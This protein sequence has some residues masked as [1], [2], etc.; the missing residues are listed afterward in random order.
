MTDEAQRPYLSPW[1]FTNT[2]RVSSSVSGNDSVDMTSWYWT[3]TTLDNEY[4][5]V[6]DF[7]LD[8]WAIRPSDYNGRSHGFSVRCQISRHL[9]NEVLCAQRN[10]TNVHC[11]KLDTAPSN[12]IQDYI[13]YQYHQR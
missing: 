5:Q 3:K 9:K 11:Y 6:Y 10:P 4:S 8:T 2:G 13:P 7:W 12:L 1:K